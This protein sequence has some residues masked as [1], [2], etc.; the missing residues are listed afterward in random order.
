MVAEATQVPASDTNRHSDEAP[1]PG[2]VFRQVMSAFVVQRLFSTSF[3]LGAQRIARLVG[4]KDSS[5]SSSSLPSD[6]HSTEPAH[7]EIGTLL[8]R[9][10]VVYD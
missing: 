8:P 4:R 1:I 9:D 2:K 7:T 3:E 10:I 5:K 6:K